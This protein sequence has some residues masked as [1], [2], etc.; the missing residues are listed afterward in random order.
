M[1]TRRHWQVQRRSTC[2]SGCREL[3]DYPGLFFPPNDCLSSIGDLRRLKLPSGF[4]HRLFG[5]DYHRKTC[6]LV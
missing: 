2:A 6:F 1:G 3:F 5:V 4:S